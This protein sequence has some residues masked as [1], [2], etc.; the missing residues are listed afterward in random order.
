VITDKTF[1]IDL[2]GPNSIVGRA[3]ILHEREDDLKTQPAGDAGNPVA[4]GVITARSTP[5]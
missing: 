5:G 2:N 1:E 4:C 3:V